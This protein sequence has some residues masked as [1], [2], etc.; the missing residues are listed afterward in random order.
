MDLEKFIRKRLKYKKILI[1]SH[2]VIGFPNNNLCERAI[3]GFVEASIDIMELQFPFS[4]PS[5]CRSAH[6]IES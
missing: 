1:T 5:L 2:S 3:T 6:F 4:D